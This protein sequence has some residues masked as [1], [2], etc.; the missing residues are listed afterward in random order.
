MIF[1]RKI[2]FLV[3]SLVLVSVLVV[4]CSSSDGDTPPASSESEP[5]SETEVVGL[6]EAFAEGPTILTSIG[7][8]ADVEMIKA[9]M[10][11][12]GI[13]YTMDKLVMADGLGDAK[14][15]IL[16]VGGSSKGLGAAGIDADDEI[17]RTTDLINAAKANDVKII[18]MHI[19]GENRRG[20]L[21]DKFIT[22][23]LENADYIIAV[24]E[25]NNDGL[26][27]KI[28]SEKNIPIDLVSSISDAIE[29][30][31]GAYK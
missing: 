15:L 22:P 2:M 21:S 30:L 13:S 9:L 4:G 19:G 23:S 14:T 24:M 5:T 7:Q 3:L 10:D 12:A 26:F 31:K 29:P 6:T 27:T 28:A 17:S 8:S 11:N 20:E 16:A 25:G 1:K 18:A